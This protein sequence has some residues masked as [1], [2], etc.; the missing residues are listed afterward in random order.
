V[1]ACTRLRR[2]SDGSEDRPEHSEG[3]LDPDAAHD[4]DEDR[5]SIAAASGMS[6]IAVLRVPPAA[7]RFR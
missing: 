3:R 6:H 1:A 7:A 5:A 4:R 2:R